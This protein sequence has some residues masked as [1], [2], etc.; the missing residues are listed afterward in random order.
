P[1]GYFL[2]IVPA[3]HQVDTPALAALL[4]V[5]VRLAGDEEIARV[6]RDCEWGVVPPFGHLYGLSTVI[7]D[8]VDPDALIIFEWHTHGEAIRLRTRDYERLER[9]RRLRFSRPVFSRV[10]R[11]RGET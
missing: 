6:F 11:A 8:A 1:A 10:P 2:A 3:T 5:P 4:G 9:P 7:D